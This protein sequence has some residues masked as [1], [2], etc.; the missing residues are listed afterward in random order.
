VAKKSRTPDPPRRPVQAPKVRTTPTTSADE[1]RRR[2]VLY[3][4]AASG[5]VGLALVL[6]AFQFAGGDDEGSTSGV[7]AAMKDAGCTYRSYKALSAR[8]LTDFNAKPKYNSF[9]PSSGPHHIQASIFGEYPEPVNQVQAVHNL[10]HGAVV[11][12]YGNK[13]SAS[14]QED[15]HSFYRDDPTALLLAPLP[16]LG[17]KIALTAWNEETPR[18]GQR[19]KAGRGYVATCPRYDE[20]AFTAFRDKHR[21]KG[22]ERIPAEFL[23]PG[24]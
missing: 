12:Q 18:A 22:P 2:L 8:H 3:G 23:E 15:L 16:A 19:R 9:P 20:D 14:T 17:N 6:A 10:E 24:N 21:F 7:Q 11:I 13:V 5:F 1:R 4:I